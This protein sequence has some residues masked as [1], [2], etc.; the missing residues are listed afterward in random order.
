MNEEEIKEKFGLKSFY[1]A[2]LSVANLRGADL[3]GADLRKADLS[4]ANLSVANLCGADLRGA[5]L[6]GA[7]LCEANLSGADLSGADLCGADL[8]KV[9]LFE[10]S[11]SPFQIVPEKGVFIGWKKVGAAIVELEIPANAKRTSSLIGR[12]CRCS[13][14]K[15]V[16]ING[17]TEGSAVSRYERISTEYKVGELVFPDSYD[18]DIRVE[19]THGIHFFIT[20][21][22]AEDY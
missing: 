10:A 7:T 17:N 1:R 4:V 5:D 14:A 13:F 11:I 6:C 19:C 21:K 20:K 3:R 9:K 2:N 16:S 22:E 8:R 18:D 12:K 15:V